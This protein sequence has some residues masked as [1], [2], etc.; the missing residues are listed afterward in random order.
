MLIPKSTKYTHKY[1]TY[2]L[3]RVF[4]HPIAN[5]NAAEEE[6]ASRSE[7][8]SDGAERV[9]IFLYTMGLIIWSLVLGSILVTTI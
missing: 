3:D 5:S 2:D 1:C 9:T 6:I 4:D 7:A 8:I